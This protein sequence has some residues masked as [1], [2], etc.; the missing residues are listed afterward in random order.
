MKNLSILLNLI[1]W[2]IIPSDSFDIL[3][4]FLY[5][6]HE[7]NTH[8]TL[9]IPYTLALIAVKVLLNVAITQYEQ[10]EQSFEQLSEQEILHKFSPSS[11]QSKLLLKDKLQAATQN[12][13][14][15][16]FDYGCITL[17]DAHQLLFILLKLEDQLW[18]MIQTDEV[19]TSVKDLWA[20]KSASRI[21]TAYGR[22]SSLITMPGSLFG[23]SD[24]SAISLMEL[25]NLGLVNSADKY[26]KLHHF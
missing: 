3:S 6:C 10:L 15:L 17:V 1:D 8:D 16:P 20:S 5:F 19:P 14:V 12:Q 13:I 7:S 4:R 21:H 18:A 24:S 11:V 25:A 22:L 9:R 26:G 23:D 2:S